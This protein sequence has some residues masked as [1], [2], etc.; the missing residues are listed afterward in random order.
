MLIVGSGQPL[1][2][3][4]WFGVPDQK[5]GPSHQRGKKGVSSR[6]QGNRME[7]G[8]RKERRQ[9]EGFAAVETNTCLCFII[10]C[11][12]YSLMKSPLSHVCDESASLS[13][14]CD[15]SVSLSPVCDKFSSVTCL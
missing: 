8:K 6:M 12:V 3:V 5:R 1:Q 15:E 9:D 11:T 14:V 4:Q 13:S 7:E 2:T 10:V